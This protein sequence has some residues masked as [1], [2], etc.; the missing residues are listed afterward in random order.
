MLQLLS[1]YYYF[2]LSLSREQLNR[3]ISLE[4]RRAFLSCSVPVCRAKVRRED[5]QGHIQ[6]NSLRH[7][8]LL[9]TERRSNQI[10]NVSL[11]GLKIYSG[12]N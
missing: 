1:G 2:N 8:E 4:C 7:V 12:S 3:H 9:L 5:F 10:N 6:N 11:S